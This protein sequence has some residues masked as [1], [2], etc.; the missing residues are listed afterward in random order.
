MDFLERISTLSLSDSLSKVCYLS[1]RSTLGNYHPQL[2]R[3]MVKGAV[4]T[5]SSKKDL[6]D[7][8]S[9]NVVP[10]VGGFVRKTLGSHCYLSFLF[11]LA[12]IQW[13]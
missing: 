8:V 4:Y 3:L 6:L 2:I 13:R 1:Y 12:Y 10:C 7:K 5:L 11:K 9:P